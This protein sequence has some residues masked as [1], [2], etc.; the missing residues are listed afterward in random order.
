LDES[1]S[2]GQGLWKAARLASVGIEMGVSVLLGW[3]IGAWLDGKLHTKPWLMLVF[4]I[5]GVVAGGRSVYTAARAAARD[6]EDKDPGKGGTR[7]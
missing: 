1:V 3:G 5:L 7:G 4:V 2:T 6:A